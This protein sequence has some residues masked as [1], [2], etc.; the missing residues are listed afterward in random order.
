MFPD[1]KTVRFVLLYLYCLNTPLPC[2]NWSHSISMLFSDWWPC[3]SRKS[4]LEKLRYCLK[5]EVLFWSFFHGQAWLRL[6]AFVYLFSS[7]DVTVWL[8]LPVWFIIGL[9]ADGHVHFAI[10]LDTNNNQLLAFIFFFYSKLIVMHVILMPRIWL[11]S[12]T[13]V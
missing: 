3:T 6:C 5:T 1:R 7:S 4:R 9:L 11:F 12:I 10:M 2:C 13:A 8:C